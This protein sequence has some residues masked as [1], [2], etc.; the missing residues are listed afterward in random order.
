M[1]PEMFCSANACACRPDTAVVNT[2]KIP[3]TCSPTPAQPDTRRDLIDGPA[4]RTSQQSACHALYY[5]I[6]NTYGLCHG[7]SPVRICRV[8]GRN[9]RVGEARGRHVGPHRKAAQALVSAKA[10]W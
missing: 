10:A 3:M 1:L 4:L 8:G 6:S 2:S 9:C 7:L 5:V